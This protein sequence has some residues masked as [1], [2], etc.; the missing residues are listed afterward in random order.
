MSPVMEFAASKESNKEGKNEPLDHLLNTDPTLSNSL[1]H[2]ADTFLKAANALKNQDLLLAAEIVDA[3][4]PVARA[5][6]SSIQLFKV[7][8]KSWTLLK[9]L[10]RS[11]FLH[12]HRNTR[13]K[14]VQWSH[15]ATGMAITLAKASQ[16]YSNNRD[17]RDAAIE[18]GEVVWENGLVKKVG[19]ADVIAGMPMDSF[20]FIDQLE[21]PFT[22]KGQ[23]HLPA[24]CTKMKGSL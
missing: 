2:S 22:K 16:V 8:S 3:C 5:S 21:R 9:S 18:E 1:S 10:P 20:H 6:T 19:L 24:S 17:F 13:D 23:K 11:I 15:G 14:L 7:P 4:V 12:P